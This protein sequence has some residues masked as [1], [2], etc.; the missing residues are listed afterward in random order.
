MPVGDQR[1][2][3][4]TVPVHGQL[5]VDSQL[6]CQTRSVSSTIDSSALRSDL[7]IRVIHLLLTAEIAKYV[8]VALQCRESQCTSMCNFYVLPSVSTFSGCDQMT[9]SH[10]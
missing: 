2:R 3:S 4:G 6:G 7:A 5:D 8:V 1:I 10:G 9:E